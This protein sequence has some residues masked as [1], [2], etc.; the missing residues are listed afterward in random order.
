MKVGD[1]VCMPAHRYKVGR[2]NPTRGIVVEVWWD[3]KIVTGEPIKFYKVLWTNG[4]IG[5]ISEYFVKSAD[6]LEVLDGTRWN[7]KVD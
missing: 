7:S 1:V 5:S 3:D 2:K 4:I 6:G